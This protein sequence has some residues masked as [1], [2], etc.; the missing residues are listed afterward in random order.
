[1]DF[2]GF[3]CS[4]KDD[5]LQQQEWCSAAASCGCHLPEWTDLPVAVFQESLRGWGL[6]FPYLICMFTWRKP[7][8]VSSCFCKPAEDKRKCQLP[9]CLCVSVCVRARVCVMKSLEHVLSDTSRINHSF[10]LF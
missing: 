7:S 5:A 6:C 1:M 4:S 10:Y 8:A 2:V 3:V 9:H